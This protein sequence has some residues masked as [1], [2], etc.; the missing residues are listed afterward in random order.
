MSKSR[1]LSYAFIVTMLGCA[2]VGFWQQNT[3]VT[4][5]RTWRF[6]SA[7]PEALPQYVRLFEPMGLAG[8]EALIGCFQST[9]ETACENAR[10]VL[11]K[12]LTIWSPTD[13]R[14]TTVTEQIT[15]LAPRF[16]SCGIKASLNL[17]QELMQ[18]Q[19]ERRGLQIA[20]SAIIA[21][22]SAHSECRLGVYETLQQALQNE[23]NIEESLQKQ[24]KSLV[25]VGIKSDQEA[26]RLAAIRLAVLPGLNLHEHLAP[27]I[28]GSNTDPSIEVRQLVLLALGE[29]EKLLST[30]EMCK[31]LND[32]DKEVQTIAER[33][34]QVRGLSQNQ[35]KLARLM[36][37]P[38]AVS[39][40]ELPGLVV[41]TSEVDTFQWMERLSKDPAPSVRAATARVL[42]VSSDQRMTS[43]LKK[44][45][46]QDED[47]TVQ[48]IAR[49]YL[50]P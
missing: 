2:G 46:E 47:Q 30:D 35:I 45:S 23:E 21:Q 40:A 4:W 11:S 13:N 17:L 39:R 25:I 50:Q 48:Q 7:T 24:A 26:V 49:F 1:M 44:L 36:H 20:L 43:L 6:Q 27:L 42:G 32:P 31:Y 15:A 22:T 9:N 41:S 18:S 16:S 34:L 8:T 33:A 38:N 12:I 3:I 28:T 10:L 29:H 37:D 5:Y 19:V 14:R